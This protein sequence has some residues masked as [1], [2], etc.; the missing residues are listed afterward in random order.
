MKMCPQTGAA[1]L[2]S[3]LLITVPTVQSV[4]QTTFLLASGSGR[5]NLPVIPEDLGLA[6]SNYIENLN[7]VKFRIPL[8]KKS[9]KPT[10][11]RGYIRIMKRAPIPID[12]AD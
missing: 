3:V 4:L 12:Y 6:E 10:G 1:I 7:M 8:L 5:E 2:I 9:R 11:R